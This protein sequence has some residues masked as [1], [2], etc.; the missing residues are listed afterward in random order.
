MLTRS[1]IRRTPHTAAMS[2]EKRPPPDGAR[3]LP[4][5]R[6]R[7]VS[8]GLSTVSAGVAFARKLRL[9]LR[10]VQLA[11]CDEVEDQ[12]RQRR[13]VYVIARGNQSAVGERCELGLSFSK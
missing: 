9:R 11:A 6:P 5:R 3:P 13:K 4:A 10:H 12:R 7:S 2:V 8:P 1:L